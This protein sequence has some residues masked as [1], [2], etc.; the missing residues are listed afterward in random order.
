MA[1]TRGRRRQSPPMEC[2]DP[3][4]TGAKVVGK[5]RIPT[6]GGAAHDKLNLLGRSAQAQRTRHPPYAKTLH[7]LEPCATRDRHCF[8]RDSRARRG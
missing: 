1:G 4:L 7:A 8:S 3:D 5:G 6:P 2:H